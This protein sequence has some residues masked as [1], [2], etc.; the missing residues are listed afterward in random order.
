M[1]IDIVIVSEV[2]ESVLTVSVYG[3]RVVA[4]VII[5]M[6][7][8]SIS[9]GVW[10]VERGAGLTEFVSF[11]RRQ[12]YGTVG[13]NRKKHRINDQPIIHCPTSEGVSEVS[14]RASE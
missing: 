1:V 9:K 7:L 5:V 12:F 6:A 2:I 8:V 13:Q 11:S 14:E 4:I 3:V 10:M